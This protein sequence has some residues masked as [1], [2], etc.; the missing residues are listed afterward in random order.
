MIIF[1][2]FIVVSLLKY[3]IGPGKK[4][5]FDLIKEVNFLSL[6]KYTYE[7]TL[8]HTYKEVLPWFWGVY[9]WLGVTYPRIVHRV[10]NWIILLSIIGWIL[11]I[12]SY[13]KDSIFKKDTYLVIF[14]FLVVSLFFYGGIS[15]YDWYL[16]SY[17]KFPLG[18]QGRYFFPLISV[19]MMII[20]SGWNFF[21]TKLRLGKTSSLILLIF[22]ILLNIY[23]QY[24]ILNTYYNL[25]S[26]ENVYLQISQYKPFL[27][28]S[29]TVFPLILLYLLLLLF[30]IFRISKEYY[31]NRL[32]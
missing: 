2:L 22:I 7:Y 29:Y 5:I 23:A 13:T 26:L 27:F 12:I 24:L 9:D 18:V 1:F 25:D 16:W 19:I 31:K 28:K 6:V 8:P 20:L 10:I 32:N 4:I 21:L 14:Y 15:V 11:K 17:S 30:T 3:N